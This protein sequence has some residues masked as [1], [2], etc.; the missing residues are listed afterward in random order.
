MERTLKRAMAAGILGLASILGFG[1][2]CAYFTY[3]RE[4]RNRFTVG[5]NEITITEEYDPPDEIVPGED[6]AFAKR[7]QVENTGTVPCYVRVRL[8]YSDSGMKEFCTNVLGEHR[9]PADQWGDRIGEFSEGRWVFG[10]DGYYYY[11]DALEPGE[12][13]SLLLEKVEISVPE[14]EEERIRE[15]EILVYGESVQTLINQRDPDGQQTAVEAEDYREA[16]DQILHENI[17]GGGEA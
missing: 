7:V 6:T 2:T 17:R 11:R 8:E 3:V 15:F 9:A 10:E 1:T 5:H 16:W 13:T 14:G 4:V 12:R